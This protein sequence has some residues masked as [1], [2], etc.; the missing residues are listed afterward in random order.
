[1]AH[2]SLKQQVESIAS[3][4]KVSTRTVYKRIAK[5]GLDMVLQYPEIVQRKERSDAGSARVGAYEYK[6]WG[7]TLS[8][9]GWLTYLTGLFGSNVAYCSSRRE[10][11]VRLDE[12]EYDP[13]LLAVINRRGTAAVFIEPTFY[14]NGCSIPVERPEQLRELKDE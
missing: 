1:M 7:V 5:H 2:Q 6:P 4:Y 11:G 9:R 10:L 13:A 12:A 3:R 8:Y 14:L